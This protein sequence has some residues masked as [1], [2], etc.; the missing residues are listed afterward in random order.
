MTAVLDEG[1]LRRPIGDHAVMRAQLEVIRSAVEDPNSP[2][3]IRVLPFESGGHEGLAGSFRIFD[4]ADD[5]D[6]DVVVIEH[7]NGSLILEVDE[8]VVHYR[9]IFDNIRQKAWNQSETVKHLGEAIDRLT[10]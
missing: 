5:A 10:L 1:I 3:T 8:D 9:S 7:N 4:F 6:Q 2:V